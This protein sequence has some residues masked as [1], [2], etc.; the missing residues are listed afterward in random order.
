M[1][2][3]LRV[4]NV[5]TSPVQAE[6]EVGEIIVDVE[7]ENTI[8]RGL[9]KRGHL[10]EAGVRRATIKA[11]ADTGTLMLSLPEDVVER[12]GAPVV[13]SA[14]FTYADGR[15]GELPI[16]GPLT[17]QIGDRWMT[18]ECTV[19]PEGA[20]ALI[21]QLVMEGLDLIAD[22]VNRTLAPR[23]ESPDMP[24]FRL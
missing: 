21:G 14:V 2:L 9:A 16:A 23:P 6:A 8:D 1:A 15:R 18:T 19:V 7:L 5:I 20:D 10:P 13:D 24:L 22:C 3:I 11:V 4:Y 17:V 12:L